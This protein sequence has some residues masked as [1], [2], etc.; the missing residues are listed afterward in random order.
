MQSA[1]HCRV[2][3][4]LWASEKHYTHVTFYLLARDIVSVTINN[5]MLRQYDGAYKRVATSVTP[6]SQKEVR[7]NFLRTP[8]SSY[9]PI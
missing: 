9:D 3:V 2:H 8:Q 5:V 1:G 6:S 4:D 7:S